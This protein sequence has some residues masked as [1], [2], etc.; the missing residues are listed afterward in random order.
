VAFEVVL[1]GQP[2]DDLFAIWC[3][4]ADR[5]GTVRADEVDARLRAACL[6]LADFPNRGTSRDD[7]A[8]G[9]RSVPFRR[10]A[11]IYYRVTR[12]RVEI[13]RVLYAGK[14]VGAA[15]EG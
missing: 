9:L 6:A 15:F 5:S 2:A 11:T 14:D 12:S 4:V 8:P 3:F 13:V 7:L 10:R 1:A